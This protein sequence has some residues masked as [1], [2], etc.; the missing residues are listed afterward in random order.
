MTFIADF[1][2]S[3]QSNASIAKLVTDYLALLGDNVTYLGRQDG[4]CGLAPGIVSIST[5]GSLSGTWSL[6]P[7]ATGFAGSF[8]AI[9][10]GTGQS[11]E[12]LFSINS[13]GTSGTW[14]TNNGHD[15]SNFDLFG[16]PDPVPEPASLALLGAGL[17][18]LGV[19]RLFRRV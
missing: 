2:T 10:A 1:T 4:T 17:G 15:L 13:P 19:A 16:T 7:G 11:L 3:N 12:G 5:N 6:N 14:A 9:H 8:V 18:A